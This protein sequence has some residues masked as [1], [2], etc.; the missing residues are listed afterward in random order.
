VAGITPYLWADTLP[1]TGLFN[2]GV[3]NDGTVIADGTVDP[4]YSLIQ[5]PDTNFP[6]PNTYV[7]HYGF[8]WIPNTSISKWIAPGS[9]DNYDSFIFSGGTYIYRT[10]FYL[11]ENFD[12]HIE[13]AYI[14]GRWSSDNAGNDILING[15][16]TGNTNP[17]GCGGGQPCS[18]GVFTPFS[19]ST[20]FVAGMNT[21]DFIVIEDG[22][23]PSGLHIQMTGEYTST[24]V[25]E[26]SLTVLFGI[27]LAAVSL[28]GWRWKK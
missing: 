5:S 7:V 6:G 28:I 17:F 13:N 1:I 10:S 3:A 9:L 14:T 21:L 8:F 15:I 20:G 4:H 24:P 22:G 16:S 19:I 26:P 2:T 27:G 11:P 25:P 18:W 23:S 12:P